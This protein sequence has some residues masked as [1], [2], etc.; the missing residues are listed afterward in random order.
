VEMK[1]AGKNLTDAEA[2]CFDYLHGKSDFEWPKAILTSNFTHLR[3]THLD[4]DRR[5]VEFPLAELPQRVEEFAFLIGQEQRA[6]GTIEEQAATIKAAQLMGVLYEQVAKTGYDDHET[7]ILLTRLL[8]LMFGDDTGLWE[9]N[10]F[11]EFIALRTSGDGSDLGGQ[12]AHLFQVLD[13]PVDKRLGNTDEILMR[14]P[15][16]NGG[17]F[18]DRLYIPTFDREMRD[19]LLTAT[20]FNW[21]TISPAIFGSLF[22]A[23]KSKEARREL[24]EHYTSEENILKVINPLFMDELRAEFEKHF[25]DSS[26]LVKLRKSLAK[27]SFLDPAC[28]C[29]NFLVVAYREMREFEL[30]LM[31]R[32][33]ELNPQQFGQ[34]EMD[35]TLG[36]Q[37]SPEQ[38]HGIEIEEW[39]ARIAETAMFLVD[40]LANIH[41]AQEFGEMPDRLPIT[42]ATKI[43]VANA[44]RINWADVCPIDDY[45]RI[46]GNPPFLGSTWQSK[47]QKQETHTAWLGVK[48]S[49][50]LDYVTNWFAISAR[51][52]NAT[53][54][55][56]GFVATSSVTQGTQPAIMWPYLWT[57]P[58]EISFAHRTFDWSNEAPG[59]AAVHCVI[60]G[61]A[62]PGALHPVIFDS[63]HEDGF[64]A[65]E[66]NP[67]LLEA[68]QIVVTSRT[69]PLVTGLPKMD[70]GSK[71]TDDGNLSRI[72]AAQAAHIRATDPV[73]AKYLRP[74]L[75]AAEL[76]Q[77][78]ERW[79][80]WL[81]N[82]DPR[83]IHESPV[84]QER[85]NAVRE[86]RA[87]ST[88]AS[89]RKDAATPALFQKIRQPVTEF[90][91][92][93]RITSSARDYVPIALLPEDTIINDKISYIETEPKL[94]FGV[95]SSSVFNT[96]NKA[97]SGRTR[98]DTLI[99]IGVTYNNF[100]WPEIASSVKE[101]I[102]GQVDSVLA[103][104]ETHPNSSLN[105][106]LAD[107]Y[108][109][110]A[111]PQ[112]L[113]K[114]HKDLDRTVLKA[115]GLANEAD[116]TTI[117]AELFTRY[118][119]LTKADQLPLL[120][121]K[122]PRKLAA[123]KT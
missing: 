84:L 39:P 106:S 65:K 32:L 61:L 20:Q 63:L 100:P 108:D 103:A 71:P 87:K 33:R 9:R 21:G 85:V 57:V 40:H 17:L 66:I 75:G 56:A 5:T 111:M 49:G 101:T 7:S 19:E 83:D 109:P 97:I 112:N 93:P 29:G 120:E 60:I 82:A 114:A 4:D 45:T 76:I 64:G 53:G 54:C 62:R 47:E 36:L 30:D 3:V 35:A 123:K 59:S 98:D 6:W 113:V 74:L 43:T 25:H 81:P 69:K 116:D 119:S 96:W 122:K 118:E 46:M 105:S 58:V 72:T 55:V 70:N 94:V 37:V 95:L 13:R 68:P 117:L 91:A 1:S 121:K 80:L 88:D 28:G 18:T 104:R 50:L 23:V 44:L 14:F 90:V 24:G 110:L 2:Q 102:E 11:A 34:L 38:F 67:Y 15:Y 26:K 77:N 86:F 99:S 92:I 27:Y 107:L 78:I 48:G 31:K 51:F 10:L 41:L 8:F 73:A 42:T 22:Q 89:T 12:L 79:C 115:F 52:V 16:V